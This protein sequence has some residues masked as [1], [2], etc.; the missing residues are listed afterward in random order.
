MCSSDL[1]QRVAVYGR[2]GDIVD[3]DVV[4]LSL[5][6]RDFPPSSREDSKCEFG[7]SR[8]GLSTAPG[9]EDEERC[10]WATPLTDSGRLAVSHGRV[11]IAA[12]RYPW[13][14]SGFRSRS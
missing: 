1:A 2:K 14:S 10:R 8:K 6:H 13:L 11:Y 3:E 5:S 9:L 12:L 4:E 7:M